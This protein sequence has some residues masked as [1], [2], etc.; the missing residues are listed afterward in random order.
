MEDDT[1]PK[2]AASDQ[3]CQQQNAI[4]DSAERALR[5]PIVFTRALEIVLLEAR[6]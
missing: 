2:L 4:R 3:P 6:R 1:C 5:N